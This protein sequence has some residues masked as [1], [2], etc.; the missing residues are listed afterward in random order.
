M[1]I[2]FKKEAE[3]Y[4]SDLL[5]ELIDKIRRGDNC[6]E[7]SDIE[8]AFQKGGQLGYN[9]ATEWH[10]VYDELPKENKKYW[11]LTS[12][13]EPKVDDW[14]SVSWAYSDDIVAWKEIV[15]PKEIRN[16]NKERK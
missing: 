8:L 4:R 10:S 7:L 13:G 5:Q 3:K 12:S 15:Y 2:M 6:Q 1:K 9:M 14:V 11:V 16:T